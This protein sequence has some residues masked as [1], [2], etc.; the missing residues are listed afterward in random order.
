MY[1][2]RKY[3]SSDKERMRLIAME[4][5]WDSY[6]KTD[7]RRETVAIMYNDYFTEYESDNIFVAVDECDIPVG[8]VICSAD[9]EQFAKKNKEEFLP[10]AVSLYNP[11]GL[12]HFMLMACLKRLKPE[13]RVHLHIDLL[14]RA[15]HQGLG[16]KLLDELSNHLYHKGY[17][18]LSVCGA[19]TRAGSYTFY[20][21]Y[22]FK[23][24]KKHF[25]FN[26]TISVH[27]KEKNNG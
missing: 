2:I 9:Y 21:K 4:T 20:K 11:I 18:Y 5:A 10:K 7:N 24:V 14:P 3:K 19:D 25:I 13:Y 27:T 16:T 23:T 12:V 6:K 26:E 17:N 15:Q 1:T 8:Y 22:G